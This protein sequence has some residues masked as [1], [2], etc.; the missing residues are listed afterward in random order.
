MSLSTRAPVASSATRTG[1]GLLVV[2]GLCAL[3]PYLVLGPGLFLDDFFTLRGAAIEGWWRAAGSDQW[4]ARPGAGAVY[5][6]VFGVV[7]ARPLVLAMLAAALTLFTG[8]RLARL[9]SLVVDSRVAT[10]VAATWLVVPNHTSLEVWPSALNILLALACTVAGLEALARVDPSPLQLTGGVVA[11]AVG[12]LCYEAV[13][14][15]I[16]VGLLVIARLRPPRV[17]RA[18]FV[19]LGLQVIVGLWMYVNWHPAKSGLR[20]WL[21][22]DRVIS[23]H[24]G[25]SVFGADLLGEA[26]SVVVLASCAAIFGRRIL[27]RSWAD[28][29][30]ARLIV[31]GFL[32]LLLG[33][34]P[35]LR[36]FYS[37]V[38]FGDRVTV[39]SSVGG[40]CVL[41]GIALELRSWLPRA[42]AVIVLLLVLGAV[43]WRGQM[44][45][46][47]ATAADDGR[48]VLATVQERYP[49]PPDERLVFGP[50]PVIDQNVAAFLNMTWPIQWL[51]D[52]DAVDATLTFE[53]EAF[54]SA[55]PEFRFDLIEL[56][57]LPA[58]QDP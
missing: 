31:G 34:L 18:A 4:L 58:T 7:G 3:S 1:R 2:V 32:V 17:A 15:A 20:P 16:V 10:A 6:L 24:F 23:G 41:V 37:P 11:L 50:T 29:R 46:R 54:F 45:V 49:D 13:L 36:Y 26:L 44:V 28:E 43:H 5:A 40:A 33:V 56:S 9:A 21:P 53:P 12:T 55:P 51:Y 38:G 42:S 47:Y 52:S 22:A 35:F 39:V 14:P 8:L 19:G 57:D 48:R 27:C 30:S 25:T